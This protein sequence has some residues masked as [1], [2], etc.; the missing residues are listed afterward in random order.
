MSFAGCSSIGNAPSGM[1]EDEAKDWINSQPP[2]EQI[3]LIN[4]SPMSPADK[5]KRINEIRQKH[6]LSQTEPTTQDNGGAPV[7][8][9]R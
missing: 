9:G 2:E 5:E 1:S 8:P 6:G 3:K 7:L 4:S